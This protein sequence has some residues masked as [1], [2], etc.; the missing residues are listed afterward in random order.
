MNKLLKQIAAVTLLSFL[1]VSHANSAETLAAQVSNDFTAVA[2]KAIP[3]VVSIKVKGIGSHSSELDSDED[4]GITSDEFLQRFFG[5]LPKEKRERS[6]EGQASGFIISPDGYIL[7]NSHVVRNAKNIVVTLNDG[8]EF[9]AKLVGHDPN[10]DIAIIKIEAKNLPFI[11][12]GNS[13]N[14]E[15]G[16]WVAAIGTPFGLQASLTVGVVS[17][18]GRNNLDISPFEDYI[19]TDAAINRGNSGGPLMSLD[20]KAIGINTAMA[21]NMSPG[22]YLGIGFAIPSNIARNIMDQVIKTG[23]VTRSYVG[24]VLQSIDHDLAQAFGL[25]HIGGALV[26]DVA[27]DSPADKSGLKQGDI[28]L[29]F[30]QQP[31]S[32]ISG[33]RTAIALMPPG[34]RISLSVLRNGKTMDIP[35]DVKEFPMS[36]PEVARNNGNKFGFEVQNLTPEIAGNLGLQN[37]QGVVVSKVDPNTPAALIGLKKGALIIGVNQKKIANVEEFKSELQNTPADRPT[38]FLVKQGDLVRYVSIKVN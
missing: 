31:V 16:Q 26:A 28:I 12:L 5:L 23:K 21:T 13:D 7:T 20:G 9:P 33:L 2:K 30:N 8:K 15:I 1:M 32:N 25:K 18:K 34:T 35:V 38:L 29:S 10:T 22:G 4:G 6:V 37:E 27:K 14:I 19:Q 36:E 3:A 11:E 17:A 24:I